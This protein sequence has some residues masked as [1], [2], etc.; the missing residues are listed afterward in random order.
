M[1]Y[2]STAA[3][4]GS[5]S[6]THASGSAS[7]ATRGYRPQLSVPA[8]MTRPHLMAREP[9]GPPSSRFA[10]LRKLAGLG[11][12]LGTDALARGV[13]RLAGSDPLCISRATAEKL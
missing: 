7:C 2:G 9:G 11:A 5:G 1:P 10:R 3:P 13:K 12:Q 4:E 8:A 6:S